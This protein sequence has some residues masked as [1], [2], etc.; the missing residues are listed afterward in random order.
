MILL[1]FPTF[2]LCLRNSSKLCAPG[3]EKFV[4]ASPETRSDATE[5]EQ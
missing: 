3:K 4:R 2:F 1:G 5:Q